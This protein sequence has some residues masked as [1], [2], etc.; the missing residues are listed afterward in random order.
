MGSDV[1]E[2]LMKNTRAFE[3]KAP[4]SENTGESRS[5]RQ[6]H[7]KRHELDSTMFSVLTDCGS[8]LGEDGEGPAATE[9]V[10]ALGETHTR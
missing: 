6:R 10:P 9:E 7:V 1:A 8:S 2:L 5:T 3:Y 4:T